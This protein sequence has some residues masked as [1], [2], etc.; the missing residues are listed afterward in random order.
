MFC[1]ECGFKNEDGAVFCAGCGA[2]LQVVSPQEDHVQGGYAQGDDAW[3][4]FEQNADMQ[5]S[6][7]QNEGDDFFDDLPEEPKAASPI[8]KLLI[9]EA[10]AAVLFIILFLVVYNVQYSA[11]ATAEKYVKSVFENEWNKVYDTMLV[12]EDSDFLTKQ[13][14]V[15]AQTIE[16]AG[17][18]QDVEI[19]KVSKRSGGF[20]SKKYSVRYRTDEGLN[21][22]D[23]ELRRKG[24]GWKVE[25]DGYIMDN[26][27]VSVP[28]G[29]DVVVD[30]IRVSG[31]LTPVKKIDGF[32]TYVIP[33]V[34]GR[35]HYVE[36]SGEELENQG[37][38]LVWDSE[39]GM[40][41]TD[42]I[43][44]SGYSEETV[45]KVMEQAEEDLKEI[46]GAASTN[47]RFS[48]VSALNDMS[49]EK[50]ED[51]IN[52][53]EYLRDTKFGNGSSSYKL[54]KYQ[55]TNGEMNGNIITEDEENLIQ[56]ELKGNYRYVSQSTWFGNTYTDDGEGFCTHS[57]TYINEDGTWKLY[58]MDVDMS[59]VY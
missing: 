44:T 34:F 21:K 52:E 27:T 51:A 25:A 11:K 33:E 17:D 30:K 38:L 56:V 2:K 22:M 54:T 13:A 55:I 40:D 42:S 36:V 58:D 41:V 9:V 26:Y 57:L 1:P 5:E 39:A 47:K 19:R 48:E 59:G 46:F 49:D 4:N 45:G 35:T 24:L 29:A 15:T 31:N 8:N 3:G 28:E 20:T 16:D 18:P 10:A 53:Y 23:L 50:K 32:D 37:Q 7:G 43:V 12:E 14:F 6:Y